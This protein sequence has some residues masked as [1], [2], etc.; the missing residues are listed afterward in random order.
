MLFE[1][2]QR[3]APVLRLDLFQ[4]NFEC[5]ICFISGEN[6][7]RLLYFYLPLC[8]IWAINVLFFILTVRRI[9]QLH[10]ELKVMLKNESSRHQRKLNKDKEKYA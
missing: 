9:I 5:S 10:H 7:S 1:T 4:F 3:Y 8:I 2:G 6:L